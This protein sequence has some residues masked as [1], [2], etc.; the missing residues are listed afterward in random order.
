MF[1]DKRQKWNGGEEEDRKLLQ[2]SSGEIKHIRE[3][4]DGPKEI[5]G[6]AG[7]AVEG[8][9]SVFVR[10]LSSAWAV[11]SSLLFLKVLNK[12]GIP[13]HLIIDDL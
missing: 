12:K 1:P 7:K 13:T 6:G 11:I 2:F 4:R 5:N 8:A 9:L 10:F 3:E